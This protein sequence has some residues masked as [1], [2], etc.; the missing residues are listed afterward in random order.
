MVA[1]YVSKS[2][3]GVSKSH[4]VPFKQFTVGKGLNISTMPLTAISF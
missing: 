2:G 4:A 1:L 3:H